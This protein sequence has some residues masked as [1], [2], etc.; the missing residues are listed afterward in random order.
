MEEENKKEKHYICTGGCKGVS[1]IPGT[2]NAVDCPF[3][4]KE[5]TECDCIDGKH[6]D[7]ISK[8]TA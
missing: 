8:E 7:F 4:N 5:L 6:N 1:N 2:C 3:H